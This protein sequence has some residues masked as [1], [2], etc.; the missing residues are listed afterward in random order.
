[1]TGE[2]R[3]RREYFRIARQLGYAQN[4]AQGARE[5]PDTNYS[6]EELAFLAFYPL[7]RLRGRSRSAAA[8]PPDSGG[9]LAGVRGASRIRCGTSSMPPVP[10]PATTTL[11]QRSKRWSGFRE[12]HFVDRSELAARRP[13][14]AW[15]GPLW[16]EAVSSRDP[17]QRTEVMKWNDDPFEP[18]GG[19]DGRSED[20]GAFLLLPYWLARY[21]HLVVPIAD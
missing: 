15:G 8:L 18:D 2:A 9:P 12:H 16:G 21:H 4:V 13:Q 5:T 20:D 3:F 11:R 10:A 17:S 7:L 14:H 19:G 6:D 1:V